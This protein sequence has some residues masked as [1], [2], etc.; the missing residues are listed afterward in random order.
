MRIFMYTPFFFAVVAFALLIALLIAFFVMALFMEM[1]DGWPIYS[2]SIFL[3]SLAS[4]A[5]LLLVT[6]LN[7]I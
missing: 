1:L 7:F 5:I 2:E 4:F 3:A 6:A